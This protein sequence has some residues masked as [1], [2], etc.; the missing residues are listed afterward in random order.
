M[1]GRSLWSHQRWDGGGPKRE[2]QGIWASG[3]LGVWAVVCGEA[4]GESELQK[5]QIRTRYVQDR[6]P[7]GGERVRGVGSGYWVVWGYQARVDLAIAAAH[8][9]CLLY[10]SVVGRHLEMEALRRRCGDALQDACVTLS[11]DARH[12]RDI[13]DHD[14]DDGHGVDIGMKL[15]LT[16]FVCFLV[17]ITRECILSAGQDKIHPSI[18]HPIHPFIPIS[19]SK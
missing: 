14:M 4:Q 6:S 7:R 5:D 10:S 8:P 11:S 2:A 13:H 17:M 15:G 19:T 18:H 3:R 9:G 1:R 12:A 16:S